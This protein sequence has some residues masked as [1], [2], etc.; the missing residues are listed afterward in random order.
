MTYYTN[1]VSLDNN[2]CIRAIKYGK[3]FNSKIQYK[4]NLYVKSD[5]ESEYKTIYC[6]NLGKIEFDSIK[7]ARE[8][9]NSYKDVENFSIYGNQSFDYAFIADNFKD[10]IEWNIDDLSIAIIDIETY[11]GYFGGFPDPEKAEHPITAITIRYLKQY[12]ITFACGEYTS[13]FTNSK[14]VKCSDEYDLCVKFLDY[15]NKNCP[16]IVSGWNIQGFDIPY[17]Y[18]RVIKICGE[19]EA[20]KLSPWNVVNKTQKFSKST[21]KEYYTYKIYGIAILDY[22]DLYKLFSPTK[23]ESYKLDSICNFELGTGKLNYD[24]YSSLHQLYVQDFEK[25]IDYNIIDCELIEKLEDKLKLIELAATLAYDTKSQFEDVFTQTRMWDAI[26]YNHLLSKN[27]IIPA[28]EISTKDVKFEG[29]YVKEPIVGKYDNVVSFDLESLY[30]SLIQ[31]YN[32]SPDTIIDPENYTVEMREIISK[33]VTVDKILNREIDFSKL[34]NISMTANGQFFKTDRQG[35]LP[36]I[37]AKMGIDRK[38]YK[39]LMLDAKKELE[40]HKTNNTLDVGIKNELNR[41]IARYNNL[42]LAKKVQANS[43]FGTLGSAYFRFFDVRIAEA[44]TLS[45]QLAVRWIEKEVDKLLNHLL[46]TKNQNYCL[47]SD[48]DSVFLLLN[49]AASNCNMNKATMEER[50]TFLDKLCDN[51]IQ[52]HIQKSYAKLFDYVGGYENKMYMKREKICSNAIFT[53]KKHYILSVFDNEGVRY[54]EPQITIVGLE[55]VKT[56]TPILIREKLK[57]MVK[58][59]LNGSESELQS[60]ILEYENQFKTMVPEDIAFPRG[61]NGI[62]EY[63]DSVQMYKKGTP[64][65]VRGSLIFNHQL[66]TLGLENKYQKIKDGDKIKFIYLKTPNIFHENV[67]SFIDKLPDEFQLLNYIDYN[68]M[69]DKV[70]LAAIRNITDSIGWSVRKQNTLSEFF[71]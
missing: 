35:F 69:F 21:G 64:I 38:K 57:G 65:H 54:A 22:I 9:I 12:S 4:P 63:S 32:L 26:I 47:Y 33:L 48:T 8:F 49:Q 1:V 59:L 37:L 20:E 43:G 52:Q 17:I 23:Q 14:Y 29:A 50:I 5:C 11:S 24:E 25:Y 34:S 68:L 62:N 51:V 15:W 71:S 61:V 70:F 31:Q 66:K 60:N 16:D 28:K 46:K 44:I 6:E 18:N 2:I 55:M 3:R 13:K 36:E 30:P 67:I 42:Q 41:K 19:I 10:E 56:S 58:I 53:G 27:V 40:E 39:K 7:S 45:G